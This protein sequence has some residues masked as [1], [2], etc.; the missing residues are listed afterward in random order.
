[1]IRGQSSYLGGVALLILATALLSAE[2][3]PEVVFNVQSRIYHDASC[4]AARRCT[5]NCMVI[6]LSEA[7]KRG[8]RAIRNCGGPRTEESK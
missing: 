3:D 7:R 8:G 1:M 2:A 4:S 6:R 5:R